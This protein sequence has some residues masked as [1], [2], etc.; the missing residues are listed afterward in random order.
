[1]R[2]GQIVAL[3]VVTLFIFG[4]VMVNSAS[5]KRLEN[6]GAT[7][8][9]EGADRSYTIDASAISDLAGRRV[10]D[11][12]L[13]KQT[14]YA[15][16]AIG[17]MVIGSWI[18][19][20]RLGRAGGL[21]SPVPWLLAAIVGTLLL[22]FVPQLAPEVKGAHRWLRVGSLQFQPSE[23]AKWGLPIIVAWHCIRHASS[24]HRFTTGMLPPLLLSGFVCGLIALEDL[25]TAALVMTVTVCMLLVAGVRLWQVLGLAPVGLL[26][27]V[28][29]VLAEPYRV[30]RVMT[31]LDPYAD[32]QGSGF[33]LVQ[34]L[35]SISSGGIEG[36]GFGNSIQKYGWLP[37]NQ[38]DFIFPIICEELGAFGAALLIG[39]FVGLVLVGCRIIGG[40]S[41]P[42]VADPELSL[43][44]VPPFSRL[45]GFGIV[46]TF[47][48]QA[49]INL[50]VTTGMAPTKGIAL[51]LVS[52]GGTGWIL[53]AF[54]LGLLISMDRRAWRMARAAG[55]ADDEDQPSPSAA[56]HA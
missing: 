53:T 22:T 23:I 11:T 6:P 33:Q 14:W 41:T 54:S 36:V 49:V 37:E 20:E 40:R 5:L 3:L 4:V 47:G 43:E 2:A 46:L 52:R 17:A 34:S 56:A 13:G 27:F 38:T 18:P 30:K 32:P 7:V 42:A 48:L 9:L 16:L 24:M 51:P 8:R 19:V 55:L 1:M 35:G 12:L 10:A 31:M 15:L 28:A 29:L 39:L 50:M 21:A 45:V 26:A 44:A 25:G